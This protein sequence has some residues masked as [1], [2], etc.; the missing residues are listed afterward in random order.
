MHYWVDLVCACSSSQQW[1]EIICSDRER[2]QRRVE[3]L[4]KERQKKEMA[5]CTF[6]PDLITRSFKKVTNYT[7]EL[8]LVMWSKNLI[9]LSS[10]ATSYW[11]PC[12][13]PYH[14]TKRILNMTRLTNSTHN[15]IG[16]NNNIFLFSFIMF[17]FKWW[18]NIRL[19]L[20]HKSKFNM[21]THM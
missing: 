15:H 7:Y 20:F 4:R 10:L 9:L 11:K 16:D 14:A 1:Y 5:E 21:I 12:I 6:R 3:E 8:Q 19:C 13:T 2:K 17:T 18:S